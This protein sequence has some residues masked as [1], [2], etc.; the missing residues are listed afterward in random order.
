MRL[1]YRGKDKLLSCF[2]ALTLLLGLVC[3]VLAEETYPIIYVGDAP[4]LQCDV[5]Y[6]DGV[7]YIKASTFLLFAT[8]DYTLESD[9]V[10]FSAKARYAD[11][12]YCS[13]VADVGQYYMVVNGRYFYISSGVQQIDE[14]VALPIGMLA[15]AVGG[16]VNVF[17]EKPGEFYAYAG[18][19]SVRPG[20][21]FYDETSVDAIARTINSEAG[22]QS[23]KGKVAVGSVIYNRV[24]SPQFP[25]TVAAVVLAYRQF[26][27]THTKYFAAT[28]PESCVIAAKIA[29]EGTQVLPGVLYFN[30]TDLNSWARLNREYLGTIG[31]HD[32]FK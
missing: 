18:T 25:N 2:C 21:E 20:S 27:G 32:F 8:Q 1:L 31:G 17:E 4:I 7:P 22:N 6:M 9:G 12:Q 23:M 19:S 14:L 15:R 13:I 5:T 30:T 26:E 11:Y 24:K 29:I 28:P 10:H 3:P 16:Y